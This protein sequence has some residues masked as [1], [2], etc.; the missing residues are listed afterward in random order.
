MQYVQKARVAAMSEVEQ[1]LAVAA[2]G[3]GVQ[4]HLI[5]VD[6]NMYYR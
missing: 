3:T 5:I 1:H 2:E 6:D 4:H